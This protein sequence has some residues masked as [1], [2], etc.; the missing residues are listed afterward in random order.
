MVIRAYP[1]GNE[2]ELVVSDNGIGLPED[3]DIN[4]TGSVGLRLI[5]NL[6]KTQLKG[7]ITIER[8]RG[9][10]FRIRFR[11]ESS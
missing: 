9:T 11:E 5:S 4:S 8:N 3:I 7:T 2:I 1:V 10:T 6:V